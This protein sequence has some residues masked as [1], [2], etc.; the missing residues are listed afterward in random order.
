MLAPPPGE[1]FDGIDEEKLPTKVP[2]DND[3][4]KLLPPKVPVKNASPEQVPLLKSEETE[5]T[6]VES[7]KRG[8]VS[9]GLSYVSFAMT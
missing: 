8:K 5:V 4:S 6:G 3:A 9:Y 1:T 7:S 2:I